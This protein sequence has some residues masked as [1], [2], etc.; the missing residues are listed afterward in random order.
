M[1]RQRAHQPMKGEQG[2]HDDD[3]SGGFEDART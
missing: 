2:E 1:M 3:G